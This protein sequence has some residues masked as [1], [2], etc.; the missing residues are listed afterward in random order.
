M[1]AGDRT[2]GQSE[3]S[4]HFARSA[5]H[6]GSGLGNQVEDSAGVIVKPTAGARERDPATFAAKQGRL[7]GRLQLLNPLADGRLT[8]PQVLGRRRE[9]A[10][11]GRLGERLQ[12][13]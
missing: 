6:L 5:G 2:C 3:V 1:L 9:A 12:V 11:L 10:A 8:D 4:R 13:R 7:Y